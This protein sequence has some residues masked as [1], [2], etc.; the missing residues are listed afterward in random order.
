LIGAENIRTRDDGWVEVTVPVS[1]ERE[2]APIVLQF[3]PDA[4]VEDPPTLRDHVV[5]RLESFL[6]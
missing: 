4:V 6:D 5:A 2:L 3:G 1:D